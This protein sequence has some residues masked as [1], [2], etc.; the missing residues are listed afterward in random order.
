MFGCLNWVSDDMV[1]LEL[2]LVV[3]S[4]DLTWS[5]RIVCRT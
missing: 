3:C 5:S 2:N 1:I 4:S